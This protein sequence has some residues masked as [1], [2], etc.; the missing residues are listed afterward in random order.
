M[1]V[2]DES[3]DIGAAARS[4]V[5][6]LREAGADE[7]AQELLVAVDED[8]S[9]GQPLKTLTVHD[10]RLYYGRRWLGDLP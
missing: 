3:M 10:N 7:V 6:T 9:A 2:A 4:L 8:V 1:I 5:E